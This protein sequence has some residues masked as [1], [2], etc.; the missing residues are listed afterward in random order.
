[1]ERL[2][3]F[4]KLNDTEMLA[5]WETIFKSDTPSREWLD[6]HSLS[7]EMAYSLK[8]AV[9][10]N[11]YDNI[12]DSKLIEALKLIQNIKESHSDF[13]YDIR[14]PNIMI[15][16]TPVGNQLVLTDPLYNTSF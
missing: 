12:K 11:N 2:E 4:T 15:R 5:V 13:A 1:M 16:R 10:E 3:D 14:A 9:R 6:R 7:I 8:D